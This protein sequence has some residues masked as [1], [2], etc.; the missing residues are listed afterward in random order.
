MSDSELAT[1][2]KQAVTLQRGKEELTT[3]V[4]A[5]G[6]P[7]KPLRGLGLPTGAFEATPE[8]A[9]DCACG[10]YLDDPSAWVTN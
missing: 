3:G 2:G 9:L 6:S 7:Q 4:C 1:K 10:L 5:N 8:D